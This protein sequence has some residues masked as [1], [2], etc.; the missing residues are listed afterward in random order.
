MARK[1]LNLRL[2]SRVIDNSV[3]LDHRSS[4]CNC[5]QA[6]CS[7]LLGRKKREHAVIDPA[8]TNAFTEMS[9]CPCLTPFN[10][11]K[12]PARPG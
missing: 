1:R 12:L 8:T 7:L 5:C 11:S 6:L 2:T 4:V 10:D 9:L 3:A